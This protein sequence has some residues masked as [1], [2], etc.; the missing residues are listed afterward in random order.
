MTSCKG[1]EYQGSTLLGKIHN[2]QCHSTVQF[3]VSGTAVHF[4]SERDA[5][6]L[7]L[8]GVI[9]WYRTYGERQDVDVVSLCRP[10]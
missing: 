10:L 4:H 9:Q 7:V 8:D 1:R 2:H 6:V 3:I 5:P